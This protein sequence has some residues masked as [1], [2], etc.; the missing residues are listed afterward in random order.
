MDGASGH[1]RD[2]QLDVFQL[3]TK[4]KPGLSQEAGAAHPGL[5]RGLHLAQPHRDASIDSGLGT[6]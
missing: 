2:Q 3:A 4:G 1:V 5:V 6:L